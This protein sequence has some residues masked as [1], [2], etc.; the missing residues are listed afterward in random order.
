MDMADLPGYVGAVEAAKASAA[1]AMK[2]AA[3]SRA[4]PK[5]HAGLECE[6]APE[7]EAFF[8][9]EFLGRW[10]LDY[11]VVGIH[12]FLHKGEWRDTYQI[13]RAAELASFAETSCGPW[14]AGFS[15]SRPPRRFLL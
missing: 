4:S 14:K 6:W 9:D 5:I 2:S 8:R 7:Y 3:T 11:L 10:S 1:E 15:L 13:S 12:M